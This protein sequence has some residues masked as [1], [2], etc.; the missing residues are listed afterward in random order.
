MY[1]INYGTMICM[2]LLIMV[3]TMIIFMVFNFTYIPSQ[4]NSASIQTR[5]YNSSFFALFIQSLFIAWPIIPSRPIPQR[6]HV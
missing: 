2:I 4:L 6:L 5:V 1:D 3:Y